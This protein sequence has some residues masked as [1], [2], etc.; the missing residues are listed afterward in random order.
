MS[1][2]GCLL[3]FDVNGGY[4][5]AAQVMK[6]LRLIT[7]AV[8]LGSTDTLI[9][10]PAGLTHH[11]MTEEARRSSGITPGLLRLSV[12]L[13]ALDDLRSDLDEALNE[14]LVTVEELAPV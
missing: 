2:P 1:G 14:A 5:A 11:L 12:G 6:S 3:A 4:A 7:P 13:E 8:S 9:Q 10:H